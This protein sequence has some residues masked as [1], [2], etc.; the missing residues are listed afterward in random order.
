MRDVRRHRRHCLKQPPDK[1]SLRTNT[2]GCGQDWLQVF[3]SGF[4]CGSRS[5]ELCSSSFGCEMRLASYALGVWV[6]IWV[7]RVVR[8][9]FGL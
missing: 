5:G 6:V 1:S 2:T 4:A 3:A 7:S 8:P 9:E